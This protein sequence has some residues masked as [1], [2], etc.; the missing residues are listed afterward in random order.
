[1]KVFVNFVCLLFSLFSC[2][3]MYGQK[4]VRATVDS[5]LHELASAKEDTNRVNIL[6]AIS[7]VYYIN[8]TD[9]DDGIKLGLEAITLAE[10]LKFN[11]GIAM[12]NLITGTN[13]FAKSDFANA[14]D[15]EL[16]SLKIYE[17]ENDTVH[18]AMACGYISVIYRFQDDNVTAL[19]Y[20]LRALKMDE[21]DGRKVDQ[22]TE[23]GQLSLIYGNLGDNRQ[24]MAYA[25]KE[26]AVNEELKNEEGIR[27]SFSH[28]CNLNTVLGNL[29]KALE[30][31]F[32]AL[33]CEEKL[34][35]KF[36]L[37][38][39]MS[40]IG[41]CY[42]EMYKRSVHSKMPNRRDLN[43]AI[44]YLKRS[45]GASEEIA[46]LTWRQDSY[47]QLAQCY[48]L[49]GDAVNSLQCFEHYMAISDSV[50]SREKQKRIASIG[51]ESDYQR[52]RLVDSLV[53]LK[54]QKTEALKLEK[55]KS[56]TYMGLGGILLLAG[57]SF[58]IIRERGKS[59]KQK[60]IAVSERKK[61]DELL[62]NILPAQVAEELKAKGSTEAKM[63]D[64]VTV[65]FTDFK[66]FTQLSEK[67]TPKALVAEINECFSAFDHIMQK[68]SVE[69]IKTIGDSYMAAGGLPTANKTHPED[70]V[71]AAL[72][73]QQYMAAHKA[74][75]EAAG[76]LYF[77]IRIGIH[78]GPVVAGIVGV[79]KF[80]Y[81]I[82][83]DTV[84]TASRMESS[85]E[86]GKVNI[87]GTTYELV[88][89]KFSC[90][91]RGEIE[92]KHKGMLKMY[93]VV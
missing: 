28:L 90:E 73:I 39:D 27:R 49:K 81:D 77:E 21:E 26:L 12:A 23:I 66:G 64:E 57:F 24:A 31:G 69:K 67:L 46:D 70:V 6:T 45:I 19:K 42:L 61:S 84:N 72:E 62:L 86:V 93:F 16:I 50:F 92:A 38:V 80:Q 82:W 75:K 1:M 55:Q 22:A 88:K 79:K 87:S 14:L 25:L 83:G 51:M 29:D 56:Y 85:G 68:Y 2:D 52:K 54:Q 33:R 7:R 47:K 18:S 20:S 59:E 53:T 15:H 43:N 91:Y 76:A 48:K 65:L 5:L 37:M 63:I 4:H 35:N 3:A 40:N 17:S 44:S 30:Y 71:S 8:D 41:C 60:K 89:D 13:Y 32:K 36:G 9:A 74:K 10:K 78:S 34:P 11:K 58:F